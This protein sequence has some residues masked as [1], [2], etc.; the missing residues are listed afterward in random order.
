M[1]KDNSIPKG[2]I[3]DEVRNRYRVRINKNKQTIHLSYHKNLDSALIS[4]EK[5]QNIK[6][7]K[8][9]PLSTE[10]MYQTIRRF[11]TSDYLFTQTA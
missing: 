11:Y 10:G 9:A 4:L 1:A 2:I 6:V 3:Y 5:A 8:F 7:I